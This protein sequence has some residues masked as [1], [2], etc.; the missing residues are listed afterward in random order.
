MIRIPAEEVKKEE[1][2]KR[3]WSSRPPRVAGRGGCGSLQPGERQ[4]EVG[5]FKGGRRTK[6]V[7]SG[8]KTCKDRKP[9]G[10]MLE[11]KRP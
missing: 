7:D 4:E 5:Y 1:R 8:E 11:I 9:A 10:L 2:P 6:S 3:V